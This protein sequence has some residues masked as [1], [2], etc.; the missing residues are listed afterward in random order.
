MRDH[1]QRLLRMCSSALRRHL[2]YRKATEAD[3]AVIRPEISNCLYRALAPGK[4]GGFAALEELPEFQEVT[5]MA[6]A[7]ATSRWTWGQRHRIS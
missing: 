1:M 3:I 5:T 2:D 6:I 4:G 7:T